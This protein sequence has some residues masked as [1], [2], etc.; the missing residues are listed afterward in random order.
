VNREAERE[1]FEANEPQPGMDRFEREYHPTNLHAETPHHRLLEQ[2]SDR[3]KAIRAGDRVTA[4][5]LQAV[6]TWLTIYRRREARVWGELCDARQE[7]YRLR[8][9]IAACCRTPAPE[10]TPAAAYTLARD[11]L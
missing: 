10:T 7:I 2:L 1:M 4:D 3:A 11:A 8:T 5:M 6:A 9:E